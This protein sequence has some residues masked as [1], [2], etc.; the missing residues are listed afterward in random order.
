VLAKRNLI[1]IVRSPEG[2]LVDPS[3]KLNG[4]GA[5]LHDQRSCWTKALKGNLAA[6]LRTSLSAGDLEH[7]TKYMDQLPAEPEAKTEAQPPTEGSHE[8]A[9]L[10]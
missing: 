10:I 7:L 1:R 2:V 3:M 5:Y 6:A 8:G 9:D 4:R